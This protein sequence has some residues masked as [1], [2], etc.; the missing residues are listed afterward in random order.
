MSVTRVGLDEALP[1]TRPAIVVLGSGVD[2]VLPQVIDRLAAHRAR[3]E[4]W[5]AAGT[6][7]YAIGTGM[8]VLL[9]SLDTDAGVLSGLGLVPGRAQPL[10][11][12]ATGDLVVDHRLGRLVG[13]ENHARRVLP[14]AQ[15]E[16]FG[17]VIA[18]V[19]E[20]NGRD[21]VEHGSIVGTRLHG[22]LFALNP[23]LADAALRQVFG[24]AYRAGSAEAVR[25][26]AVAASAR[27]RVLRS[28]ALTR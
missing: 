2:A 22:P 18:G 21:G 15:V 1:S 24:D 7:L 26:D 8:E 4:E 9:D 25:A 19:G 27:Q 13:F 20:Q 6:T 11:K 12:R 14:D 16:S 3:L 28:L 10:A 17:A 5:L 23:V